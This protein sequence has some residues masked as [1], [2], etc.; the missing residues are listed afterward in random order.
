MVDP[1]RC[2]ACEAGLEAPAKPRG[3]ARA[4]VDEEE[5]GEEEEGKEEVD[6]EKPHRDQPAES[7]KGTAQAVGLTAGRLPSNAALQEQRILPIISDRLRRE[8]MASSPSSGASPGGARGRGAGEERGDASPA[9]M[10][11]IPVGWGMKPLKA[12]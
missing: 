10:Q 8:F 3:E 5:N 6:L 12:L 4:Q 2:D 9:S 1:L 11:C 7:A